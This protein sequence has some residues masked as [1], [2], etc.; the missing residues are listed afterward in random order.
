MLF[1]IIMQLQVVIQLSEQILQKSHHVC[2]G[3]PSDGTSQLNLSPWYNT[4]S[5][6]R[7]VIHET[8]WPEL[9]WQS[10]Q[11]GPLDNFGECR[12]G[13][14]FWTKYYRFFSIDVDR[15]YTLIIS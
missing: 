7:G 6:E 5:P 1:M 10:L 4:P 8:Q 9:D 15:P 14:L 3:K 11:S 13:P 12:G 2:Q